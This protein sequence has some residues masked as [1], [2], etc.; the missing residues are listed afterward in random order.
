VDDA[1]QQAQ[2]LPTSV[3]NT[4]T[5]ANVAESTAEVSDEPAEEEWLTHGGYLGC[6][7]AIIFGCLIAAFLASPLIRSAA[8]ANQGTGFELNLGAAIVMIVGIAV[9]GRIGWWIGKRV[10]HEYPEPVPRRRGKLP[11]SS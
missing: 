10:Y 5:Q 11:L 3:G 1:D 4:E 2:P 6:L 8:H 9:F 7:L